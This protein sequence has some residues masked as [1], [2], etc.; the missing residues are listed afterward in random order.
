MHVY[1]TQEHLAKALATVSRVIMPQNSMAVLA[2]VQMEA[3]G[4][5]LTLTA[6]DLFTLLQMTI[7]VEV[8]EPGS[9]VLPANLLTE[10]VHRIPTATLSLELEPDGSKALVKYG[11][12]RATLYGYGVERLPDFPNPEGSQ[13][14][15]NVGSSVFPRL[16]R[17]LLFACAKDD[18]RPILKGVSLKVEPGRLVFAATDGS[19]L[20]HTWVP[21][22]DYRGEA[23]QCVIPTKMLAEAAR[24]GA[25][26]TADIAISANL[27]RLNLGSVTIISRLLDGQYPDYQRVIPQ[28]YVVQGRIR[29]PD[30]RGAIERANLI[31]SKDR[32]SAIR[33]RHS[34]GQLDISASAA[35]YGQTFESVEFDSHG[36]EMELLFNPTFLL[37]ALRSL[38]SDEAMLEFSGIQSPLRIREA[39]NHQYSHIVL[40]LRQLV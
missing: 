31:A 38:D 21:V 35:E 22:P 32:S 18:T 37:D 5:Q 1:A 11:R 9:T 40:P 26:D 3:R 19:R 39:E 15:L 36:Q 25:V 33:L 30:F 24:L 12:N 13:I 10:L 29:V 27:I 17:Q 20:S 6:T 34:I 4:Q 28:E 14:H 8:E 23:I 2:G 16:A 7:D